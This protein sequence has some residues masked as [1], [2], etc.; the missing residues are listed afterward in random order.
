MGAHFAAIHGVFGAHAFLHKG[1]PGLAHDGLP[2]CG[3]HHIAGIPVHPRVIDHL[4][5]RHAAQQFL[6]QQ[7]YAVVALNKVAFRIIKKAAVKIAVP[8]NA[9]IRASLAHRSR[10]GCAAFWQQRV[11]HAVGKVS[12]WLHLAADKFKR[13]RRHQVFEHKASAAVASIC[14]NFEGFAASHGCKLAS[15]AVLQQPGHIVGAKRGLVQGSSRGGSRRAVFGQNGGH[16]VAQGKQAGIAADGYG[17]AAHQLKAVF[18]RRVVAARDH[19]AR[20][21][22]LIGS[23]IIDFF[24]AA[25]AD[26]CHLSPCLVQPQC[27]RVAQFRAGKAGIAPDHNTFG[28]KNFN[29][30]LAQSS[31]QRRIEHARHTAPNIIG[32]EA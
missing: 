28:A 19:D 27:Q 25:H 23:G 2:T 5:A 11:G 17:P 3:Q 18:I 16:P 10:R 26:I 21:K 15:T 12:V 29:H 9:H 32:F 20:A 4:A 22:G 14:N 8:G 13:Q 31:G 6:R 1:V 24:R 30:G 7:T